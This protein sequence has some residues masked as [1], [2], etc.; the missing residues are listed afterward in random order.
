M[1]NDARLA[2]LGN[3]DVGEKGLS[4]VLEGCSWGCIFYVGIW[5]AIKGQLSE[6]DIR[7]ARFGGSSSGTLGALGACLNKSVDEVRDIYES[8]A[9]VA[10]TF[11][12]FGYMSIYHEVVLRRWL[13]KGGDEWKQCVNRLYVNVTRFICRSEVL[14][15]WTS[16]DD[17][18]DAMHC[19]MHIPFYMNYLKPI[20]GSWA[21]DGGLSANTFKIDDN[22]IIV[23]ATSKRG[24]MFPD[25]PLTSME[26]FAPPTMERRNAICAQAATIKIPVVKDTV[27][28]QYSSSVKSIVKL[29]FRYVLT[30]C[31][32]V[33]R[34][35]EA[36]DMKTTAIG[37]TL[38]ASA[39]RYWSFYTPQGKLLRFKR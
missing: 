15:D 4:F 27:L 22:T 13:P 30:G 1:M 16:N 21:I 19:S 3:Q 14:C 35:I 36:V 2:S 6:E 23:T 8:L 12:V 24:A 28:V 10:E 31:I 32:W 11:G 7:K 33:G 26:C 37:C 39:A 17:I 20:R 29:V 34:A 9:H 25:E 5:A 18:V 38:L